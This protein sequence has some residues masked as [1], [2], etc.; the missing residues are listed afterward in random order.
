MANDEEIRARD[1]KIIH[2]GSHEKLQKNAKKRALREDTTF[3][4]LMLKALEE[5][6]KRVEG[7][8]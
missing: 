6:L 1:D 5:H 7:E 2:F 8:Q 3:H 4:K